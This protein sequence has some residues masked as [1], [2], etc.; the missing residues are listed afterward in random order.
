MVTP[1]YAS[2]A[3]KQ[4]HPQLDGNGLKKKAS[5]TDGTI[6][7]GT[8]GVSLRQ[9]SLIKDGLGIKAS[10]IIMA[11]STVSIKDTGT[12]SKARNGLFLP[13]N[14]LFPQEFQE[15]QKSVDHSIFRRNMDSHLNSLRKNYQDVK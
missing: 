4:E 11:M 9:D 15:V 8:T 14:F 6:T 2:G 10:G 7:S 3:R 13:K 5:G 1:Q 12:G